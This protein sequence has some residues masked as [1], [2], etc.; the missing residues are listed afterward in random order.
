VSERDEA[1]G[2]AE[3]DDDPPFDVVQAV[4]DFVDRV[5]EEVDTETPDSDPSHDTD[6]PGTPDG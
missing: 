3:E 2:H 6:D 1:D 5:I 4:S